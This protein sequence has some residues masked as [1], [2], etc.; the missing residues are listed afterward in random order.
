MKLRSVTNRFRRGPFRRF[1]YFRPVSIGLLAVLFMSGGMNATNCETP[2]PGPGDGPDDPGGPQILPSDHVMGSANARVTV[3][4]YLDFQCPFC[5]RFARQEF[6]D[7]RTQ[8]IDTGL[9]RWV[10]R[11]FPLESECNPNSGDIHPR[12]CDAARAS[13]CASDQDAFDEFHDLLFSDQDDL[14]DARFRDHANTLGLDAAQ[15]DACITG[16]SKAARVTQD[17]NSG[18]ALGVAGTPS[19]FVNGE[20]VSGFRTAE[21]LG[22]I[23]DRK[24][25]EVGG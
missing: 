7:L 25:N 13:E 18:G 17:V 20:S 14:S 23:I 2:S 3:V 8:Y 16:T 15:F 9:V 5:G 10:F 1:L 4:E 19:F 6:P 24:L 11:H 21:Q 22:A 12:A